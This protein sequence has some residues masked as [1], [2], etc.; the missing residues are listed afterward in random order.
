M[1]DDVRGE[2]LAALADIA[3]ETAGATIDP[4]VDLLDEYDLDSMD[5]LNLVTAVHDRTGIDVPEREQHRLRTVA[6]A[7]VFL[8]S[9]RATAG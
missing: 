3:P 2:F 8:T 1:N 9:H 4:H 5:L 7:V 6:G